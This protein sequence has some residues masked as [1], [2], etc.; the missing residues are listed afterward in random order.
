MKKYLKKIKSFFLNA[1]FYLFYNIELLFNTFCNNYYTYKTIKKLNRCGQGV[2]IQKPI[3]IANPEGVEC[4]NDVSFASYVHIWGSGKV[5]I[6]DRTMIGT[7]TSI[8]SVTHDY[9]KN[10]MFGT[11]IEKPV[12]IGNDVWIGSNSI[13]M[14][15]ITIGEG[16]VIGAGSVVTKN[17]AAFAIVVGSPAKLLKYREFKK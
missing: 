17:V 11:I 6:G 16:A 7:H 10:S 1:L 4:G 2:K 15:G 3:T 14:P 5:F 8:T 13:I 12:N 9:N